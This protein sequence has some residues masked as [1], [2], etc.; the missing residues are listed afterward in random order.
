MSGAAGAGAGAAG[1]VCAA[2]PAG[3]VAAGAVWADPAVGAAAV[4]WLAVLALGCEAG[5]SSE[6]AGAGAFFGA[7]SKMLLVVCFAAP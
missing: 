6:V 3:V 4:P 7:L 1:A 2:S 5:V